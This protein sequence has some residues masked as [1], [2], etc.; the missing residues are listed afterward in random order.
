M[1]Y[2]VGKNVVNTFRTFHSTNKMSTLLI[3]LTLLKFEKSTYLEINHLY[4]VL[5]TKSLRY[6]S[7]ESKCIT[8][9]RHI[10]IV[11]QVDQIKG[12]GKF[13]ECYR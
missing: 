5:E 12:T 13:N 3:S 10:L 11:H 9:F 2:I 4:H 6:S 1:Y 8:R 7:S